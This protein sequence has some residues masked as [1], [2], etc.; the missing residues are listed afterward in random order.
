MTSAPADG[1]G[2]GPCRNEL[3]PE[4]AWTLESTSARGEVSLLM[5]GGGSNAP[6]GFA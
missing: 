1:L 5:K 4:K 6:V 2:F 3:K